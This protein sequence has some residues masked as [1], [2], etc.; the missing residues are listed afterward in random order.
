MSLAVC[1]DD[2]PQDVDYQKTPRYVFQYVILETCNISN[3]FIGIS[4]KLGRYWSV[5][6]YVF[7][8]PYTHC[9]KNVNIKNDIFPFSKVK[10]RVLLGQIS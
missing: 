1:A 9:L 8:G 10:G 2:R 3:G 5:V 4:E 7:T 6:K